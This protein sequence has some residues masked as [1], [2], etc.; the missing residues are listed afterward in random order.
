[1]VLAKSTSVGQPMFNFL[2]Q[3]VSAK[4]IWGN[5]NIYRVYDSGCGAIDI[6]LLA[7]TLITPHAKIWTLDKKLA[8]LAKKLGISFNPKLR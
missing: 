2:Y 3:T 1:M 7:S 5:R 4:D 6:S 8:T